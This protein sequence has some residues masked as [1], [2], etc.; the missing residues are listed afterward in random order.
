MHD[1]SMDA[2]P[3]DQAPRYQGKL[4]YFWIFLEDPTT[5]IRLRFRQA[6]RAIQ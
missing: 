3:L 1:P 4:K 5:D 6:E 2:K